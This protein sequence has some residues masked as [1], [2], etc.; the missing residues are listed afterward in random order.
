M[1]MSMQ[2]Y[3]VRF[4]VEGLNNLDT[5]VLSMNKL[6][7]VS[8]TAADTMSASLGKA[9]K[10]ANISFTN[11]S[12]VIGTKM[13]SS[14]ALFQK[15]TQSAV[16]NVQRMQAAILQAD[17]AVMKLNYS[18]SRTGNGAY[19]YV[20]GSG[21]ASPVSAKQANSMIPG[22]GQV[23]VMTS[24]LALAGR[25]ALT[26]PI[27]MALRTA[28]TSVSETASEGVKRM[29]DLDQAVAQ[30][31]VLTTGAFDPV[32]AKQKIDELS[33]S[34]G[35]SVEEIRDVYKNLAESG[36]S[37]ATSLE[38]MNTVVRGSMASF[39][40]GAA[41]AR[42][43]AG[44]LNVMGDSITVGTTQAEKL[45]YMMNIM[46][47]LWKDNGGQMD[48]Y[49]GGLRNSAAAAETAGVSFKELMVNIATLHTGLQMGTVAGNALRMALDDLVKKQ[50]EVLAFLGQKSLTPE[51]SADSETLLMAV[52]QKMKS[53]QD[54]GMSN[55][56]ILTSVNQLFGQRGGRDPLSLL[57]LLDKYKSNMANANSVTGTSNIFG[58]DA[59]KQIST[60]TVQFERMHNIVADMGANFLGGL[61][62]VAGKDP[63][64]ILQN[65]N[66]ELTKMKDG[67]Q[68]FGKALHDAL[69]PLAVLGG[70]G[71]S[72]ALANAGIG[73]SAGSVADKFERIANTVGTPVGGAVENAASNLGAM[74][75][76][77]GAQG[78][79]SW[80]ARMA[81]P[82]AGAEIGEGTSAIGAAAGVA[83]GVL[84]A[85]IAAIITV[86]V[87]ATIAYL[88]TI[89]ISALPSKVPG[90]NMGDVAGAFWSDQIDGLKSTWKAITNA[91]NPNYNPN[92]DPNSLITSDK[93]GAHLKFSAYDNMLNGSNPYAIAKQN[94]FGDLGTISVSKNKSALG[95]TGFDS[96]DT[97]K[98]LTAE[99][100][101]MKQ[102]GIDDLQIKEQALSNLKDELN[103]NLSIVD[104]KAL[105]KQIDAD[106][107]AIQK[108]QTAE[109]NKYADTLQKGIST[110]LL[111]SLQNKKGTPGLFESMSQTVT[112]QF[113]TNIADNASK[114]IM[115]SGIGSVSG[116]VFGALD[117][118]T[119]AITD[120]ILKAHVDGGA[121]VHDAILMAF[122]QATGKDMSGYMR[123]TS[124]GAMAGGASGSSKGSNLAGI[125]GT[126]PFSNHYVNGKPAI[127]APAGAAMSMTGPNGEQGFGDINGK[128][129]G[130]GA[131]TGMSWGQVGN[132]ASIGVGSA[133][134]ISGG[135]SQMSGQGGKGVVSGLGSVA[136]GIGGGAAALGSMG[137][138]GGLFAAGGGAVATGALGLLGPIGIALGAAL[139]IAS[140]FM[141]SKDTSTQTQTSELKVASKIDVSNQK[142]ELINRNLLALNNT[143]ATYALATS[144]YFSEK[145]GTIDSQFALSTAR[146][147]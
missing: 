47:T 27:W 112:K 101:K 11:L 44:A 35:K 30:M 24:A 107:L 134:M 111:N 18:M 96:L 119:R 98:D 51:Q 93:T 127:S 22:A 140:L 145:N 57:A 29:A 85:M 97:L 1:S 82:V 129:L 88:A 48:D 103:L 43:M 131:N 13:V 10:D 79:G 141:K 137:A 126:T 41:L 118:T 128:W 124:G 2:D 99:Y 52:V 130:T 144:S 40:D 121:A 36:L 135:I 39:S 3:I 64:E 61:F 20:P 53:M 120:P 78:A 80:L 17:G 92:T 62:N 46:Q 138:F 8:K 146:A 59:D 67:A 58:K 31:S 33:L 115:S 21:S 89:G 77:A 65:M 38:A 71:I 68:G 5:A 91:Y 83:A 74:A 94:G 28:M 84:P 143:M 87:P 55:N 14:F 105:Q 23:G 16:G 122:Q 123:G 63:V 108:D 86:A 54:A 12:Q 110:N 73:M 132:I 56:V 4:G 125:W 90:K 72:G 104:H 81:Q 102:Y 26:I 60:M 95:G 15:G 136:S 45:N 100:D 50:P 139:M 34:T 25:A 32:A 69:L 70:F 142:L 147:Y 7:A 76:G 19:M 116:G 6:G 37:S 114:L 106:T 66:A 113:Q 75:Y 109:A 117:D 42:T 133:T 49:V 9:A